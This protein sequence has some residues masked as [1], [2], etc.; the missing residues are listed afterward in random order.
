[1]KTM[2]ESGMEVGKYLNLFEIEILHESFLELPI[3]A[4][5][6][7][8]TVMNSPEMKTVILAPGDSFATSA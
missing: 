5:Q 4:L 2:L 7:L 6:G 3:V 8:T 1:M